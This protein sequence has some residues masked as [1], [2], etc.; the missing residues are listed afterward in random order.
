MAN[1]TKSKTEAVSLTLTAYVAVA[2]YLYTP[3]TR[4]Y[5]GNTKTTFGIAGFIPYAGA[6]HKKIKEVLLKLSPKH[7]AE[8]LAKKCQ[9]ADENKFFSE[10]D[11]AEKDSVV[12]QPE[13]EKAPLILKKVASKE[14]K[15]VLE[16]DNTP[17]MIQKGDTVLLDVSFKPYEVHLGFYLN[18]LTL[19]EKGDYKGPD[20]AEASMARMSSAL[21]TSV[22]S[23][24]SAKETAQK[25]LTE[26]ETQKAKIPF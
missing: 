12:I 18:G 16:I 4:T 1:T 8:W 9:K 3:R 11:D 14:G 13:S 10:F 20:M 2:K 24:E 19:L 6:E 7:A 23:V 21:E 22:P 26:E 25:A 15:P 5:M 17:G